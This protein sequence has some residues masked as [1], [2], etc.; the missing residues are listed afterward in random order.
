MASEK[1]QR[2]CLLPVLRENGPPI[3]ELR[4]MYKYASV[5]F[6]DLNPAKSDVAC[7]LSGS[8]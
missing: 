8:Y 4:R 1:E 6:I 5:A 7:L 2:K 3:E